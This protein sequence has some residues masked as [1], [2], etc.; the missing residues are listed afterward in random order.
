MH[1]G[2]RSNKN[3]HHRES[4][5]AWQLKNFSLYL[6]PK[7]ILREREREML[8]LLRLPTSESPLFQRVREVWMVERDPATLAHWNCPLLSPEETGLAEKRLV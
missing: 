2:S 5:T 1:L 3:F 8:L 6:E 7:M 4:D